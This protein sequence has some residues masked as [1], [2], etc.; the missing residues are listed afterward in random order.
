M[1]DNE[2]VPAL[3]DTMPDTHLVDISKPEFRTLTT[4]NGRTGVRLERAFWKALDVLSASG[5]LKRSRFL[6]QIV[7]AANE[8]DINASSAIRSTTVDLLLREVERLKPLAQTSGLIS[9]LQ[10]GP[11]PAFALDQRKRLV[12]SN[13]EFL[14]YLRSV[15]G[16]IGGASAA[17]AAQLSIERP[18][19]NLFSELKAGEITE[20]GISIRCGNRDRRTRVRILMVPPEPAMAL[21]GYILS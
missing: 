15:A 12:Q 9:M 1:S 7:A 17:D 20:C 16:S 21:V 5:G 3:P 13:P 4:A 11:T 18:V 6:S 8:A 10:A 2:L 19:D 14:R